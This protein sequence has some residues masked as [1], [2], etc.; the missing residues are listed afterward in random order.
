MNLD[1]KEVREQ[2]MWV[3]R[4]R[5]SRCKCHGVISRISEKANMAGM[6]RDSERE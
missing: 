1:L 5:Y 4:E 3:R 2:A 6:E